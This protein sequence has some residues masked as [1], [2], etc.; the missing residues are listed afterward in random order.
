MVERTDR[1]NVLR[2]SGCLRWLRRRRTASDPAN[3][4]PL[5]LSQ[6]RIQRS[7]VR[8]LRGRRR[9]VRAYPLPHLV[10]AERPRLFAARRRTTPLADDGADVPGAVRF[11]LPRTDSPAR[12]R[13][14]WR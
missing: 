11:A 13:A 5:A 8:H 7:L 9:D 3:V 12:G 10:P 6:A 4:R 14:R 2:L 1:G